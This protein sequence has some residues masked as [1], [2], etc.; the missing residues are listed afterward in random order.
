M[1]KKQ[2]VLIIGGV[3]GGASTA[4]RLRR[5]NEQAEIILFERGEHISFAN[6][7]LP[8]YIGGEIK[9]RSSLLVQTPQRF[10]NRFNIDVR[11]YHEVIEIHQEDKM[12]TVR[13]LQT[14]EVYQ[15]SY[16]QLVLSMGAEPIKPKIAG[17]DS[18]KIFTLRN[19]PD[20][21]KMKTYIE[22]K[23]PAHAV[24]IGGGFIGLEMVE[25]LH[26]AGVQVALI[27]AGNQVLAPLDYDMACEVHAHLRSKGIK[28]YLGNALQAIH[29]AENH[30]VVDL[31][32]GVIK[33]DMV[34]MA[35]G[36]R[37]ESDI[38]RK[39]GIELNE[40]GAIVVNGKMQTSIPDIFAI[41][42]AI[43][44]IDFVTKQPTFVPLAG[45]AN[46]QGR[47]VADVICG[48]DR[49][50]QGTQGSSILKVFDLTV[51]T[52]G[53][54]EKTAKRLQL[55]YEKSFTHSENHARYYPN[56]MD[57]SLKT[58]YEK[59]T[60][61]I[62]GVQIVGY[63]GV[64]KRC[65][66]FATAIRAQMT[67]YDLT[68]LELCYAPP[69]GSAKDAVNVAGF[70]IENILTD[71]MHIFH[72]HD[73]ADLQKRKDVTLLDVRTIE[74]YNNGNISG[75]INIPLD[76][77]RESLPLLDSSKPVY[78]ACAIGLRGYLA[79]RILMQHGFEVYNLS[80][81]YRLY[82][83]IDEEKIKI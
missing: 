78:V 7:G 63:G 43:E 68:R 2:K 6:C 26:K 33:T 83:F 3:A 56:A 20:T 29:E 48:F 35:I 23:K 60:G 28:L 41:G 76:E 27:E 4:A 37:P 49:S 9:N 80:G 5:L 44:V 46:K 11:N 79:A 52:T 65:D 62:L 36:V 54:N 18:K 10:R 16:D 8:Y 59:S 32:N 19:I 13:N 73:I 64:D 21:L 24:V 39:A 75:F 14:D 15:E 71:K 66:I 25:N 22:Q 82:Q 74:E 30:V 69:F 67:A 45:P 42:D 40:R 12:I 31:K 81:G 50:Y 72:W 17:L 57:M 51:A 77:L 61:K 38:A 1:N 47:I 70:V 53:I 55:N 58:I 34:I